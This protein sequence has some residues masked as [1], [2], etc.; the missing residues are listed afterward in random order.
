LTKLVVINAETGDVNKL[1]NDNFVKQ[2]STNYTVLVCGDKIEVE[3]VEDLQN[4][5]QKTADDLIEKLRKSVR[6][7]VG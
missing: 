3:S 4:R 5:L 7:Y 6:A 1:C 2:L